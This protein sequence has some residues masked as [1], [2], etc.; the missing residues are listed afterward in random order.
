MNTKYFDLKH[1]ALAVLVLFASTALQA[2]DKLP[3]KKK[4][5]NDMAT[6]NN[7]FMA[8]WPDAGATV[9]VNSNGKPVTRTSELWTRAVYYEG[10]MAYNQ[11]DPQK[12]N[13]DYAIEWSEKE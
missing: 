2:Q 4:M 8:K 10:L 13:L 7:Y 5:F 11:V 12:K 9:T 1:S 3:A 6:A